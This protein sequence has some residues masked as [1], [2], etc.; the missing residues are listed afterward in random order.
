MTL[1]IDPNG[2]GLDVMR[3][4]CRQRIKPY[5]DSD[6]TMLV[7]WYRVEGGPVLGIPTCFMSQW[8]RTFRGLGLQ[9]PDP[10]PGRAGFLNDW[11]G[12]AN[13]ARPFW[14]AP[15]GTFV[16]SPRQW[17]EGSRFGVDP[18]LT[19]TPFGFSAECLA[20]TGVEP[21]SHPSSSPV[22]DGT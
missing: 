2:C 14:W 17:L 15:N 19:P 13:G 8:Q 6:V 16:G 11:R 7:R 1:P 10:P 5:R 4:C 20:Q 12:Y 18:P 21:I 22:L 3:T 9:E